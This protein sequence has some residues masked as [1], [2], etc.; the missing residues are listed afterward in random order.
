[1]PPLVSIVIPCHRGERHLAGA[2]E[3]CLRQTHKEIEVIVVDDASPDACAAIAERFAA[4]DPRVRLIRRPVNGGVAEAFNTGF[5]AARGDFFTR[6]AQD[7]LFREDAVEIMLRALQQD[8]P[9]GLVYC[10]THAMRD[11]GDVV[12]CHPKAE[13]EA[14]LRDGNKVGLC[15]MWRR[16]VWEKVG[17][18][19]AAYETAEDYE[20]WC[21]VARHFPLIHCREAPIFIRYHTQMDSAR[22]R[23]KQE[24]AT[25]RVRARYAPDRATARKAVCEGCCLAAYLARSQGA[26]GQALGWYLCALWQRPFHADAWRGILGALTGRKAVID[27]ETP[28]PAK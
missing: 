17:G 18:F 23:A 9:A 12:A 4:K 5:N 3:S 24:L 11:N 8:P 2:I 7:D 28:R 13:P 21:R 19:D 6:L 20:Y 25:A 22:R 10:N 15:V 14:A 27:P 26:V 1:M 16:A